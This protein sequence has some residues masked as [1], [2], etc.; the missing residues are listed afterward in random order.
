MKAN[1]RALQLWL[2]FLSIFMPNL[3]NIRLIGMNL[4]FGRTAVVV[5]FFL[6]LYRDGRKLVF[7][8]KLEAACMAFF[9]C[10]VL[11]GILLMLLR[12][13]IHKEAIK[14]I[15]NIFMGAMMVYSI[16]RLIGDSGEMLC[17]AV[18]ILRKLAGICVVVGIFEI[19]SGRHL[20]TS[21]FCDSS[22]IR[23]ISQIYG[24]VNF[25]QATGFQY[26]TNDFC[27]FLVFFFPVFLNHRKQKWFDYLMIGAIA[28]IC[29]VNSATLCMLTLILGLS[30]YYFKKQKMKFRNILQ[31]L[32]VLMLLF[33]VQDWLQSVN[34]NVFSLTAELENHL[35]N[36]R[37]GGGSSYSRFWTYME[38]FAVAADS[39]FAGLGPANFTSYVIANPS[40]SMLLNPHNLWLEIFT[41]YGI[42]ILTLYVILLCTL[43]YKMNG[44]YK[45]DRIQKALLIQVMLIN[46]IIVGIVPSTFISYLY[47]WI[48]LALG[49][50][51]VK[52]YGVKKESGLAAYGKARKD[53]VWM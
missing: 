29:A 50:A 18:D 10:W 4:T 47:Q 38:S 9:S 49:I 33:A 44:I 28:V 5:I 19:L 11:Y 15:T 45:R 41:E 7:R 25:Y 26:G 42:L 6:C 46:Y 21:C 23:T 12:G 20:E 8:D 40:K 2:L 36:Y 30:F 53:G 17:C 35:N 32:A 24:E 51:A 48:L 16:L 14:E 1:T 22:Y 27:S 3:F 52:I 13:M 43:F 37:A 39:F 31:I 34:G